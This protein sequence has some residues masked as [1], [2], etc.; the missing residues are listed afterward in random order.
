M[1]S[2]LV[3]LIVL[4]V[5]V[6]IVVA[7]ASALVVPL[8]IA[9]ITALVVLGVLKIARGVK[10]LPEASREIKELTDGASEVFR[11]VAQKVSAEVSAAKDKVVEVRANEA[12]VH[13]H[14]SRPAP[15]SAPVEPAHTTTYAEPEPRPTPRR[16]Y[17]HFDAD[18]NVPTDSVVLVMRDYEQNRV[19][20][21]YARDVIHVL[22]STSL[23]GSSI[24]MQIDDEFEEGTISWDRFV[25]TATKAIDAIE[26]NCALLANRVQTFDV[27]EYERMERYYVTGGELKNGKQDPARIERWALLR[28]T[29]TEMDGLHSANEGLL[30]ELNK[31]SVELAKLSRSEASGDGAAIAEEV[32]RL[33]NETKYYR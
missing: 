13:P 29:I 24:F 7:I 26:R 2:L 22:N 33:A 20:G 17:R 25:S 21:R 12:R 31:L 32:S 23:Q 15:R 19:V 4:A 28:D 10:Q 14:Q 16:P 18:E 9:G 11:E 27:D 3:L 8:L 6:S 1:I 5:G 30:L